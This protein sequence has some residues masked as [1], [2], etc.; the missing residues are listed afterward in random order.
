MKKI[1][2]EIEESSTAFSEVIE[3]IKD[4]LGV[5]IINLTI[6]DMKNE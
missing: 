4:N 3:L 5:S 6:E 1:T 2:I